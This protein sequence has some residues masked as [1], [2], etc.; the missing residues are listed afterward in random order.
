MPISQPELIIYD[1]NETLSDISPL[2]Q[3]FGQVGLDTREA[4]TWV[5]EL[6]ATLPAH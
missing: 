5:R 4:T 3:R 1:V 2:Q 6:L